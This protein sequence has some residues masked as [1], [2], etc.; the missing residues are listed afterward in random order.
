[1]MCDTQ[2]IAIPVRLAED[3]G[4]Q[5][6]DAIMVQHHEREIVLEKVRTEQ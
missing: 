2:Q 1:M 5:D 3:A 6:G 4:W